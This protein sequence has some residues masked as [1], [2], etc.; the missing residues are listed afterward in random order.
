MGNNFVKFDSRRW[1][2]KMLLLLPNW[3]FTRNYRIHVNPAVLTTRHNLEDWIIDWDSEL[4]LSSSDTPEDIP[5]PSPAP[6]TLQKNRRRSSCHILMKSQQKLETEI[7]LLREELTKLVSSKDEKEQDF[8]EENTS[9]VIPCPPPLPTNLYSDIEEPLPKMGGD[10]LNDITNV[11]LRKTQKNMRK[12][13]QASVKSPD[14]RYDLYAILK[15]RY[16]AI[17]SPQHRSFL[18]D[19]LNDSWE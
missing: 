1:V 10:V 17:H 15:R 5:E 3:L 6:K 12:K 11:K 18:S 19:N 7:R 9:A 4:D 16:S 14:V 13:H 2:S 8:V